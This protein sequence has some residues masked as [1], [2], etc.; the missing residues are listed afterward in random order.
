[1]Q[2]LDDE[3]GFIGRDARAIAR[4]RVSGSISIRVTFNGKIDRISKA[5]R[6]K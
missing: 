4:E 5:D 3:V 1:M 6:L 2:R